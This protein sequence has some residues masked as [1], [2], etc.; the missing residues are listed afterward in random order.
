MNEAGA[1]SGNETG[2]FS[3]GESD[4]GF[5]EVRQAAGAVLGSLKWLVE[6]TERLID[7]PENFARVVEGGRSVVDAFIGGFA[8]GANPVDP[9][10][11]SSAGGPTDT[12]SSQDGPTDT[13]PP[14]A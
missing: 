2:D 5:D 1:T 13:G 6:A 3:A 11:G 12:G 14:E 4:D 9:E 10:P 8:D 7:D